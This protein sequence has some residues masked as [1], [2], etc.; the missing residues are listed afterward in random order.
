MDNVKKKE[1]RSFQ[2]RRKFARDDIK[3]FTLPISTVIIPSWIDLL[4]RP[5]DEVGGS[6]VA[7]VD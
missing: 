5:R 6:R 1:N 3:L 2:R 4:L 7:R